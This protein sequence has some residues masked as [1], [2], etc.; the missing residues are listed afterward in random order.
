MKS[1]E[2]K[3]YME[4]KFMRIKSFLEEQP[5]DDQNERLRLRFIRN[6]KYCDLYSRNEVECREWIKH[7]GSVMV[8]TDFHERYKVKKLLGEGSFAKVYLATNLENNQLYAIKAF[9]KESL[10]KQSKGKAAIRNEIEILCELNHSNLMHISEVHESKNSLYLVCEY[11]NG[12]SLNDYLK[13]SENFLT[14]DEILN[15]MM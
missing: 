11:L 7:L 12:G 10:S 6:L 4:C 15:I 1:S 5:G 3:G 8:R 14:A 13:N 2:F 9:S